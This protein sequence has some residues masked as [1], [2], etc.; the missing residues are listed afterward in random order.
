MAAP[1]GFAPDRY[2]FFADKPG[3]CSEIST[4]E[5]TDK[6]PEGRRRADHR[7]GA[8]YSASRLD[9]LEYEYVC[10]ATR[11]VLP[12]GGAVLLRIS[13]TNLYCQERP[14]LGKTVFQASTAGNLF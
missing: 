4:T 9:Q 2:H 8:V 5:E 12:L 7:R 3:I 13:G 11:T 6:T 14:V 1:P 10:K